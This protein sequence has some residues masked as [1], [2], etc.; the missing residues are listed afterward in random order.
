M[1]STTHSRNSPAACALL[2]GI[3]PAIMGVMIWGWIGGAIT[4][5]AGSA[6][7][8]YHSNRLRHEYA[9]RATSSSDGQW[10]VEINGVSVGVMSDRDYAQIQL[11]VLDDWALLAVQVLEFVRALLRIIYRLVFALPSALVALALIMLYLD[12]GAAWL[13]AI[14]ALRSASPHDILQGARVLCEVTVTVMVL[15][16]GL[17]TVL[18]RRGFWVDHFARQTSKQIRELL[19]VSADGD[20]ALHLLP[21][22]ELGVAHST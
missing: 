17:A 3:L 6:V 2:A 11:R 14:D 4:L 12:N 21:S 22:S 15:A 16:V 10:R 9:K 5:M 8:A 19:H 7:W 18:D 1:S 20:M 13:A